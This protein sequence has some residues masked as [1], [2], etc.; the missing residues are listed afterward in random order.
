MYRKYKKWHWNR[1]TP[2]QIS[3]QIKTFLNHFLCMESSWLFLCLL[4]VTIPANKV[5]SKNVVNKSILIICWHILEEF[6]CESIF[7]E[8]LRVTFIQSKKRNK[9]KRV[10]WNCIYPN[11]KYIIANSSHTNVINENFCYLFFSWKLILMTWNNTLIKELGMD[12][13]DSGQKLVCLF[14]AIVSVHLIKGITSPNK[15]FQQGRWRKEEGISLKDV[16]ERS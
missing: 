16:L 11:L 6:T 8:I 5:V 3:L 1:A 15:T 2:N 10:K 12:K 13:R 4:Y 7:T 9:I 14:P